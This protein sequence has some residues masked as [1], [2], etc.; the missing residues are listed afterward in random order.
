MGRVCVQPARTS[1]SSLCALT[2]SAWRIENG[3]ALGLSG[4]E[5]TESYRGTETPTTISDII[6]GSLL[7]LV[8]LPAIFS[9]LPTSYM[10][11]LWHPVLLFL[12]PFSHLKSGIWESTYSNWYPR[13]TFLR[14]IPVFFWEKRAAPG[15]YWPGRFLVR[16]IRAVRYRPAPGEMCFE[17]CEFEVRPRAM[18]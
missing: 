9:H 13:P 7:Q 5:L 6:Y 1:R 2:Y 15:R 10:K 14:N 11:D 8:S 17:C 4:Q 3:F 12:S 18:G 16:R